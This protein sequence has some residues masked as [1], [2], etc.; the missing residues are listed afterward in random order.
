MSM[1]FARTHHS[2]PYPTSDGLSV[3]TAKNLVL[4]PQRD[5]N[6]WTYLLYFLA[7]SRLVQTGESCRVCGLCFGF[8]QMCQTRR[9]NR[10]KFRST[11]PSNP[12]DGIFGHSYNGRRLLMEMFRPHRGVASRSTRLIPDSGSNMKFDVRRPV[13]DSTSTSD[14]GQ[15]SPGSSFATPKSVE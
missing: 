9:A 2:H 15:A 1:S 7:A 8:R 12:V 14:H 5:V 11:N 6:I 4:Q 13:G 3:L 10:R